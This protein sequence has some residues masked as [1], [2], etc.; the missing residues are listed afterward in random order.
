[1]VDLSICKN[2]RIDISIPIDIKGI[3][4]EIDKYNPSSD[5]YNDI[6]SRTTSDS[7]TDISLIDRKNQF[8]NNNMSLC[9]EDC[10]LIQYRIYHIYLISNNIFIFLIQ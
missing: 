3:D 2:S 10:N 9:E 6:C 5:Y 4:D 8:I 7:G 1:M